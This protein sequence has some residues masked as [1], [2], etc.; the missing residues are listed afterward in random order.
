MKPID[1]DEMYQVPEL[2]HSEDYDDL[3]DIDIQMLQTWV[4]VYISSK[5]YTVSTVLFHKYRGYNFGVKNL[6]SHIYMFF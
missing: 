1:D 6:M 5:A 3:L 4:V 2:F